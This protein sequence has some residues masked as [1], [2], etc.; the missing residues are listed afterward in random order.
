MVGIADLVK[1]WGG[2]EKL[3]ASLHETGEVTVQHN[4]T[5]P[6]RSGAERQIDVLVRHRQGLYEHLIVIECKYWNKNVQ[7]LHVDALATTVREVGASRGVIFSTKGFQSGAVAQAEHENIALFK[8]RDLTDDEWGAPGQV[9][10]FFLQFIQP[11]AGNFRLNVAQTFAVMGRPEGKPVN[12]NIVLAP[13]GGGSRT[14]VAKTTGKEPD[15]LE[16][17]IHEN[18]QKGLQ[19]ALS[20]SFTLNGGEECERYM[21]APLN[22]NFEPHLRIFAD[23]VIVELSGISMDLGIKINQSRFVH[24]RGSHYAFALAVE[25]RINGTVA[26]ASREKTATLTVLSEKQE[27]E[28][29]QNEEPLRNGSV[30][31]VFMKGYFD[32]SELAGKTPVPIEN[33]TRPLPASS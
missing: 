9:V 19:Q 28:L 6:G 5:L 11:S 12:L 8:V 23:D 27:R 33:V 1:D 24:D 13:D 10:D 17:I 30:A 21:L 32:F 3:V 22:L 7:R 20:S 26:T 14:P 31:R 29:D 25:D 18:I 4:V 15:T 2:F 16:D